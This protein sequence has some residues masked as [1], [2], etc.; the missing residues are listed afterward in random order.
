M[1]RNVT[2]CSAD[3]QFDKFQTLSVATGLQQGETNR[4]LYTGASCLS[5]HFQLVCEHQRAEKLARRFSTAVHRACGSPPL[6]MNA[7]GLKSEMSRAP[8]LFL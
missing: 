1:L 6:L 5:V 4:L 8:A 7:T 2:C 3:V